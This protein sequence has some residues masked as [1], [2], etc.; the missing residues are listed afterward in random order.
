MLQ[1]DYCY[2]SCYNSDGDRIYRP[3]GLGFYLFLRFYSPMRVVINHETIISNPG[4]CL[5][6]TPDFPQDYTAV[7]KFQNSYVHFSMK[8]D[9]LSGSNLPINQVFYPQS[10]TEIDHLF[11]KL[12]AEFLSN[13]QLKYE[14]MDTLIKQLLITSV[15]QLDHSHSTVELDSMYEEFHSLRLQLLSQC[16][17]DW[18][19]SDLYQM[20]HLEKSQFYF[21]YKQFFN[22]SPK[23]DLLNARINRAK[24]L[25][26]NE[27]AVI[28]EVA[29]NSG[30]RSASHFSRQF[31]RS[32]GCSPKMY[33]ERKVK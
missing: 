4:A 19:I 11:Q 5:L 9:L 12:Q 22:I 25:L 30:F 27:I 16:E 15:R 1:I 13:E 29:E 32:V 3:K 26:T 21:Y 6:Y 23:A 10:L 2:Y 28:Q 17:K 7:D 20:L 33:Q 24:Q 31:K 8:N 14:M 18:Q